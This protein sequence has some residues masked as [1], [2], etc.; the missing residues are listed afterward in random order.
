[1]PKNASLWKLIPVVVAIMLI[2]VSLSI[3]SI[4]NISASRESEIFVV[5]LESN[6][7]SEVYVEVGDNYFNPNEIE[8]E[9]GQMIVFENVGN[10]DHTVTIEGTEYDEIISPGETVTVIIEEEGI[11]DLSCRFHAGQDGTIIVG[12]S[13]P[14]LV[15]HELNIEPTEGE[16]PLEIDIEISVQNVGDAEGEEIIKID[17][18]EFET[19]TV[20]AGET[21]QES[22]S[23]T[24]ELA[25]EYTIEFGDQ[26]QVVEVEE[27]DLNE[28][29]VEV[30]D[31]YFDPDEI[32]VEPGQT[33]VFENVGNVDHTVTIEG[34][35]YDEIIS[36]GETVTVIIEEEG[37]YD[38][39]CRF[40]A[41]QDGTIAVGVE[42]PEE[43]DD[44]IPGF[45]LISFLGIII[46][47]TLIILIYNKR[48]N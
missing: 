31:N 36:P 2:F 3:T 8:V 17:E 34:T 24:F 39:S 29:Y 46:A 38:L 10:I 22:F 18:E 32:E 41:G 20:P 47:L 15:D 40:H 4:D 30:G 12:E 1:M 25:G 14:E 44:D 42:L 23:Y 48:K 9:P 43:D 5:G 21:V 27:K 28:M 13:E 7:L 26:T 37:I 33:I 45:T 11:Y 16:A 19:V 35:E 6:D